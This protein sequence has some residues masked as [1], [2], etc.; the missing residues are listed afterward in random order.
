MSFNHYYQSELTALR[1]LGRRFAERNPALAPFLGQAGRDPDVERL[2][3]GF[4]F[5]T[6]RLRQKLDDELPELSH[7]LMQLLWPNYMRP[8]PAFSILQFDPLGRSGPP[9][10]VERDTPVESKPV[11][12]VRCRFRTC[13]PTEVL[14]LALTGLNYSV[15]GDGS[16]LNLRLEMPGDGHL[17]EVQLSRL[18]LHFAGERYISQMLYLSLLRNLEGIELIP[19]DSAGQPVISASG[20]PMTFGIPAN[21]V[22]PV[23]FAEEEALIPYPLNTFRGYR[24]L[25]EYFAFQDKFLFVDITGLNVLDALPSTVLE[26]MRG[27]DLRFEIGKNGIQRLHPTLDNVKLYCT[28]IVN[29]FKHDAEPIRL[30]GKQDEYLLLPA[31]YDR[32]HCG[33]YSVQSVTGWNPGGLGY[34]TYVPFESF[35]HDSSVDV[36]DRP[37]YSVRQR[38]SPLHDGLDTCLGFGTRDIQHH[39]TLSI[40]LTCTNQNLPRRL[41]LGDIDQPGEKSPQSLGFRNISPVTSSFAP[42]LNQDF[43]WKLISNMSLNYLSLADVNALKVILETYDF[44]RYYDEQ[45][46]RTSKCLLDGLKSIRHRHVDRLHRGLPVRGLRTELTIDPQGYLGEGDLFVF[47]SVLNEFFAL[48]ASLNSYHELRVNS[49]QGEV[50]QWTPRMGQQPLL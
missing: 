16:L 32:E 40:E 44:P 8:L 46:E 11:Q 3:E 28:P 43:L 10:R 25:Q 31:S 35:E 7:S 24:Y 45:A 22:Q 37:Y 4:A 42:P 26:Q 48:Y 29:L 21:R 49:T 30:D 6:G 9:L 15:K 17:G 14:P 5:L 34:R 2:L 1:Q 19:L 41:K 38:S 20:I 12:G 23:G 13:Y 27:V 33:V 36:Q 39:E 50:Y 18:R 47:A